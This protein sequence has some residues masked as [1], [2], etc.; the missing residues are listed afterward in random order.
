MTTSAGMESWAV[1]TERILPSLPVSN[2]MTV[3]SVCTS[4]PM[5]SMAGAPQHPCP[6]RA[7]SSDERAPLRR[8]RGAKAEPGVVAVVAHQ[9]IVS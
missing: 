7:W 1:S 2:P 9:I 8:D 5:R 6:G 3:V 4:I